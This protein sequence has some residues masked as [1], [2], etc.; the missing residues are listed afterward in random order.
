MVRRYSRT[1]H[2]PAVLVF[3]PQHRLECVAYLP[4]LALSA[5]VFSTRARSGVDQGPGGGTRL[6]GDVLAR[7]HPRDFIDA[8]PGIKRQND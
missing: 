6:F 4:G 1:K 5:C 2:D 3:S 8:L 7:E